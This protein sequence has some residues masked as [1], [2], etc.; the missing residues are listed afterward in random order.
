MEWS[1]GWRNNEAIRH[2]RIAVQIVVAGVGAKV[3]CTLLTD[4]LAG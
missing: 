4:T 3:F 2:E 1:F